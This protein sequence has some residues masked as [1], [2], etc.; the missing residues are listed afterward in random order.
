M[1][2]QVTAM[3]PVCQFVLGRISPAQ[4]ESLHC[5]E[6][7][8]TVWFYPD[9]RKPKMILDKEQERKSCGCAS[10]KALGR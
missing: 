10:C 7:Q 6:C 1:W 4:I 9:K 2:I 8:A 5:V 3:C